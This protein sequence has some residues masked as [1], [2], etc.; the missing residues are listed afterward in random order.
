[1]GTTG[2][3]IPELDEQFWADAKLVEPDTTQHVILQIKKSVLEHFETNG[4]K[5]YKPR[6]S[7]VLES[8]MRAQKRRDRDQHRD[9]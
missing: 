6:I 9:H 4:A 8:Y 7:A 5:G 1:M 3:V 2:D